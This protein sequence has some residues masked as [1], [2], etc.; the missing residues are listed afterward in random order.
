MMVFDVVSDTI[1][2]CVMVDVMQNEI[3]GT[4]I[5]VYIYIQYLGAFVADQLLHQS[6]LT[7][8]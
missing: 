7:I 5:C 2:Y 8:S 1:L 3:L 6:H 4:T